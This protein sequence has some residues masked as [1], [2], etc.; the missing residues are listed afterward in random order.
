MKWLALT[1]F[2]VWGNVA[3]AD[4]PAYDVDLDID[5]P[6]IGIATAST[7]AWFIDLGPAYCAPQCDPATLNALDRPFAGHHRP[8][9]SVAGTA[10]S[11][12]VLGAPLPILLMAEAPRAA[13][14]DMV[15]IAEAVMVAAATSVVF[16]VGARR[17]RPFL[18]GTEAPL[19]ERMDTNASLSFFSGHTAYTFDATIATWFTLNRLHVAPKWRRLAL[20]IGLTASAF[21][22][23]SRVISGDHFPSDVMT[24]AAVGSLYGY[25]IPALHK[26]RMTFAPSITGSTASLNLIGSF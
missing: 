18:Y 13:A 21:V 1:L 20:G 9:W 17:P 11:A 15:V 26:R 12:F 6:A 7:A 10:V 8:G 19:A 22:A 4:S 3:R 25:L 24:G 5:L 16:E 2:L 23:V 14:N